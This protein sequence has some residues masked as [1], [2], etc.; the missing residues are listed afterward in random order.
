MQSAE[1]G[2]TNKY[3]HESQRLNASS[4]VC[5]FP[6]SMNALV[7]SCLAGLTFKHRK[8]RDTASWQ[9]VYLPYRKSWVQSLA[10]NKLG[11]AAH[12]SNLSSWE[13]AGGAET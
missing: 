10:P 11:V 6:L 3:F 8:Q 4:L 7:F 9:S 1:A 2:I 13:E 5:W 12:V